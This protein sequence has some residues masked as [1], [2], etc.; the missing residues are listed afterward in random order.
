VAGHHGKREGAASQWR[1]SRRVSSKE[2][3]KMF[4]DREQKIMGFCWMSGRM[5]HS[6]KE[7]GTTI[8]EAEK[9]QLF[10]GKNA[11]DFLSKNVIG[12]IANACTDPS[13][14]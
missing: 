5:G 3:M 7:M 11:E 13:A 4:S 12:A 10:D 2:K 8:A 6:L 14:N 1:F 9:L